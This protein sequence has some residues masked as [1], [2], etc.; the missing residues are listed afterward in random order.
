MKTKV[1]AIDIIVITNLKYVPIYIY[2]AFCEF[3]FIND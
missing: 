1:I 2:I 3:C